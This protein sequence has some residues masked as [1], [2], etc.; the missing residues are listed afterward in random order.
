MVAASWARLVQADPPEATHPLPESSADDA[1]DS[2]LLGGPELEVSEPEQQGAGDDE[3]PS[4]TDAEDDPLRIGGQIYLRSYATLEKNQAVG[5]AVFGTPML[6]DVYLDSRPAERVRGFALGRM[7]YDPTL[8]PDSRAI[9]TMTEGQFNGVEASGRPQGALDQLWFNFDVGRR[10]FVTLGKQHVRWGTAQVWTPTDYLHLQPRDPLDPFDARLGRTMV[11]LN[12]PIESLAWNFYAYGIV[13][14]E[15]GTEQL[16]RISGA[17]RAEF[18]VGN[19]ELGTGVFARQA[20]R[21]KYAADISSGVGPFDLYGEIG[22]V[23]AGAVDRVRYDADAEVPAPLPPPPWETPEEAA[24]AR[25]AE[26]VDVVYPRYRNEGYAVQTAVGAAYALDYGGS[27]ALTL[28]AEYFYNQLGYSDTS[29]YPGLFLPRSAPLEGAP[30]FYYL[31]RHY[32]ALFLD[33]P[34]P[35][36]LN[37]QNF[38]LTTIGN[39]S[40]W[41]FISRLDYSLTILTHLTFE[42]FTALHYGKKTGE[43]RLGVDAISLD[44]Q[45][46]SK[47]PT[48]LDVGVALRL[49]L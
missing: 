35:G 39:Y 10:L 5:D 49:S 4:V 12:L 1:R 47:R 13:E 23:D 17:A 38:T 20:E 30:S 7:V 40:D 44:G 8:P 19:T 26:V 24:L 48:L 33:L 9:P 29:A 27:D 32:G 2:A 16:K 25:L 41:S 36:T 15:A 28:G 42:A 45:R 37:L 46:L 31:G 22:L 14:N 21:P 6:L 34:A 18:V 3:L 43:F 11:K